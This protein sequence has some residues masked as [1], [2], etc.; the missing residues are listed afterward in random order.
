MTSMM[1]IQEIKIGE[2]APLGLILGPCVIES[3]DFLLRSAEKLVE[4]CPYP[5]VFKASYDKANRS[6]INSFRGVGREKGLKM[7]ERVKKEFQ[8]PVT[9]DIHLPED[10]DVVAEVV[11]LIQIPSFLCRQTDLL[12]A[13]ARTGL[14]LHVKK[15]QFLAPHDMRNVADKLN[16]GGARNFMF[17]ERGF[18]LGYNN[19]VNDF[20][21]IAI[22][23]EFAPVCFDATHSMQLPTARGSETGGDRTHLPALAKAAIAAGANA[24]YMETHPDPANA[25]CDSAT[26]WPLSRLRVL[27]EHLYSL[28]QMIQEQVHA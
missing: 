11:D 19:L 1:N 18:C 12:I 7:L 13:A 27:L 24:I 3:E 6:S 28:H 22:M 9:T 5:F 16:A 8:I 15:G 23:R 21:S 26:Q 4:T 2:G 14:P 25:K 17:T 10:A 20:R